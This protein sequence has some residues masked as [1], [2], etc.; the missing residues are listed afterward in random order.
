LRMP[1]DQLAVFCKRHV[2]LDNAGAGILFGNLGAQPCRV[3][4]AL[5]DEDGVRA[6]KVRGR[7]QVRLR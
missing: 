4:V 1:A 2:A 5:R 7:Q 3:A 6:R